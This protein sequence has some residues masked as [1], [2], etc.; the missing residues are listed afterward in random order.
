MNPDSAT[1][2]LLS[3]SSTIG[4]DGSNRSVNAFAQ[5]SLDAGHGGFPRGARDKLEK[6]RDY[7][8]VAPG[9]VRVAT[10]VPLPDVG[11]SLPV[12]PA[13]PGRLAELG[14]RWGLGSSLTRFTTAVCPD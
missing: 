13:D 5:E 2:S 11:G 12:T 1:R 3:E 6:A 14:E 10:D 4:I 9:V 7:L 8:A